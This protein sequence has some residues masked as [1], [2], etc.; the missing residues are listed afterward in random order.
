VIVLPQFFFSEALRNREAP[1]NKRLLRGDF[2][3]AAIALGRAEERRAV[4]GVRI[5]VR[6]LK[7]LRRDRARLQ[8]RYLALKIGDRPKTVNK[9][10]EKAVSPSTVSAPGFS[11]ERSQSAKAGSTS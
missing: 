9:R 2:H 4:N 7:I 11:W 8:T 5:A 3:E 1:R 6:V 10:P